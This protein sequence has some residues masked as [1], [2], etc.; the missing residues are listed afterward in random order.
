MRLKNVNPLGEVEFPLIR[1]TLAPGEEFD[2]DDER[3]AALLEQVGNFELVTPTPSKATKK[4][5]A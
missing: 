2:I 3:G 4:V 1:R 5:E